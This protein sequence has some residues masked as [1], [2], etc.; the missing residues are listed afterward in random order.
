MKVLVLVR[1]KIS[2]YRNF[3]FFSQKGIKI[4]QIISFP[5]MDSQIKKVH[6]EMILKKKKKVYLQEK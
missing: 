2:I 6:Q 3:F 1:T 4:G 5:I